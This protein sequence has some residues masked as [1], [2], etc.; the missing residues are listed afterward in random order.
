MSTPAWPP[1]VL[2]DRVPRWVRVRDLALTIAAW[3]L[4]AYFVRGALLL[5]WD[6]L[7]Y[8]F[9]ELTTQR[10]PDWTAMWTAL[11]PFF[12]VAAVLA[13]W[14]V[15]WA[16]QRRKTLMQQR[17]MAQPPPLDPDVHARHFGLRAADLPALREPRNVTV[18]FDASGAITPP[19]S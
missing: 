15:F 3:A 11:A 13:A 2:P 10:A 7:G 9:F 5:I 14:L 1:L 16:L 4:L 17:T 12:A 8:P 19:S 6:W 18:R